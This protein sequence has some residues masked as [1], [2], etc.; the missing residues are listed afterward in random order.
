MTNFL[1]TRLQQFATPSRNR[2]P[3]SRR[4]R[5]GGR[6]HLE[7]LEDRTLLSVTA[8]ISGTTLVVALSAGDTV[9]HGVRLQQNAAHPTTQTDVL[10]AGKMV[11]TFNNSSFTLL[12]VTLGPGNATL[13]LGNVTVP[14][15]GIAIDEGTGNNTLLG[16]AAGAAWAITSANAGTIGSLISFRNVRNLVGGGAANTLTGPDTD[17]TWTLTATNAGTV[18]GM[19]FAGFTSLAG[20]TGKNTLVGPN[21]D[22]TWTLTGANAGTVNGISFTKFAN[23]AGGTGADTFVFKPA[24]KV[25]G[26]LTG[27]GGT[28]TL[29][30]SAFADNVDVDLRKQTATAADGFAGTATTVGGFSQINTLVG[31]DA[32]NKLTGPN[33]VTVWSLTGTDRGS[34]N[35]S[36]DT[37][38]YSLAYRGFGYLVG[39]SNQNTFK[40]IGNGL[41]SG[42]INGGS[43][44]NSTLDYSAAN[45]AT[46]SVINDASFASAPGLDLNGAVLTRTSDGTVLRLVDTNTN[47]YEKHSAFHSQMVST[48]AF[49]ST[50]QFR[51]TN[52][53]GIVDPTGHVGADGLVF[54]LQNGSPVNPTGGYGG[55]LGYDNGYPDSVGIAFDTWQNR[56]YGDTSSN[57]LG[58]DLNGSVNH[59][60]N[61]ATKDVTPDF[62]NG[63]LW[64]AWVNYDG[65]TLSLYVSATGTKPSSPTLTQTLDLPRVIGSPFAFPGFT[66]ATGA[67]WE[68]IDVLN[69]QF[70]S[71]TPLPA[72]P[73]VLVDLATVTYPARN[74]TGI[75]AGFSNI[76]HVLGSAGANYLR[77]DGSWQI[78]GADAGTVAPGVTFAAFQN[79]EGTARSSTF[80]F[81]TGASLGGTLFT[82]NGT[83]TVNLAPGVRVG[84]SLQ[85]GTGK[86]TLAGPDTDSTWT[87]TGANAGTVNGVAFTKFAN[88]LGGTGADTFVFKP[89]GSV[90]GG[91]DGGAGGGDWLDYSGYGAAVTVNL[92]AGSAT[93]VAKAATDGVARIHNVLGSS[94]GNTLT[95]DGRADILVGGA[96]AD[97]ITGGGGRNLLIGGAGSDR[98]TGG[99]DGDIVIGGSVNFGTATQAALQAVLAEWLRTDEN[100][101]TRV[102]NLR[103]GVGPK[104]AYQLVWGK[105]VLGDGGGNTLRG[106]DAS[107]WF[108]ADLTAGRDIIQDLKKGEFVN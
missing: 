72:N 71:P 97:V 5:A 47:G 42:S 46:T 43:G 58:I 99:I 48:S 103:A 15:K 66:A 67:G 57:E 35:S 4:P 32:A 86:T 102:A 62:D 14:K 104:N 17:L 83:A 82:G 11:G 87:L 25:S 105:T 20:G 80:N 31:S 98:V 84:G 78:A 29:D 74:A 95:G 3:T 55:S 88:L 89:A 12:T 59:A 76:Q 36:G 13:D 1:W 90:S 107:D 68:N 54:V 6:F 45:Y 38:S 91:I 26:T 28:D 92:A 60:G 51:M 27:G 96:G 79:L 81:G 24:G 37:L 70:A 16:P 61:G 73:G 53:G 21:A 85:G 93:G 50:F 40:F 106:G 7:A 2:R 10:D 22:R 64:Q 39:G 52:P 41:V 100:Y 75:G 19:T 49:S 34:L 63:K 9:A 69:W 77:D 8:Q 18:N 30:Y 56:E 65:T 33:L 44:G 94:L 23:L 101:A 108:F